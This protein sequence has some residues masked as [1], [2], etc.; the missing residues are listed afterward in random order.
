M[1]ERWWQLVSERMML[2]GQHSAVAIVPVQTR[3]TMKWVTVISRSAISNTI[4]VPADPVTQTLRFSPY[5]CYSLCRCLKDISPHVHGS[6]TLTRGTGINTS[7]RKGCAACWV[8][9]MISLVVLL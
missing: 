4:P 1:K 5:P 3:D 9:P 6:V 2:I 8:L 7:T